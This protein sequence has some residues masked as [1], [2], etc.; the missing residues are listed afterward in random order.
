MIT[1]P[2]LV[3]GQK[4]GEAN[5]SSGVST[6]Q[7]DLSRFLQQKN[8]VAPE[9]QA[10]AFESLNQ[11]GNRSKARMKAL[12]AQ[13]QLRSNLM[14][15]RIHDLEKAYRDEKRATKYDFWTS[16]LGSLGGMSGG[17]GGSGG[18]GGS[19]T[20]PQASSYPYNVGGGYGGSQGYG[21]GYGG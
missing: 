12:L 3:A 5:I 2:D 6:L 14:N 15:M 17:F 1:N 13:A 8:A 4:A 18:S 19:Q 9:Y 20:Q 7:R 21:F 10:G 16:L 11:A